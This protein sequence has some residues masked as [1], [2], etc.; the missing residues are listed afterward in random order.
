MKVD[1]L[2]P[3]I[4]LLVE[5]NPGDIGLIREAFKNYKVINN[6]YNVGDGVEA[7]MFLNK[8]GRFKDMPRPD[9]IL[10]DLNLPLMDGREVLSRIKTD[11][12]LKT[13]PVII[14]TSSDSEEDIL[15]AYGLHANSYI[16]KPVDFDGLIN[17]VN[18]IENFWF[19][20]VKLPGE[21]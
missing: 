20:I 12:I 8:E 18:A 16:K 13:I 2:D 10:L 7:M 21:G 1:K 14:L 11:P 19:S 17:V 5:D 6:I 9:I 4:I 15:K 3:V